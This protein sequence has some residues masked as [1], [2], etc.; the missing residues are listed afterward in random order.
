MTT[1]P[2]KRYAYSGSVFVRKL[3]AVA[4]RAVLVLCDHIVRKG[5]VNGFKCTC[6]VTTFWQ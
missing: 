6:E 2:E 3:S 4:R 1:R 5:F